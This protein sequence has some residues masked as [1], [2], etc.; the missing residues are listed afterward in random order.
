MVNDPRTNFNVMKRRKMLGLAASGSIGTLLSRPDA[1]AAAETETKDIMKSRPQLLIFDVNETL[2]DLDPLKESV[3]KALGGRKDLV[4]LWFTT[5]LHY[6]LV[7]TTTGSYR[8]FGEI[9][10]ATM[11]M[12][13][14]E[15]GIILSMEA[16]REAIQPITSL[17][18][19]GDV[20][21]G[22]QPLKDAGFRMITLT[23][24]PPEVVDAQMENAGLSG[25]FEKLL[26]IGSLETY[27]PDPGTYNW[28]AKEM[29]VPPGDCMLVAAHGWDVTGALRAGL[30]AGFLAR[31]G[32]ALYPLSPKPELIAKDLKEAAA[33]LVAMTA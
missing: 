27:K 9:G 10:A 23:N 33:I 8:K 17:P 19:H 1:A 16:A 20:K 7:E 24:S 2:L 11:T 6:S 14:E 31:P 21:A 25:F 12:V 30:R 4:T 18:A 13:A 5:M 32:K 26:S 28:A 22:L 29:G 3:T 15:H